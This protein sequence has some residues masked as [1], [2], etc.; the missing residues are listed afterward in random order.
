VVVGAGTVGSRAV[1]LLREVAGVEPAAVVVRDAG[2]ERSFA[3][4]RDLVTADAAAADD[5]DVLVEVAGGTGAAADLALAAL[6]RGAAVVTANKAALAERWDEFAPYLREGLVWCEA[7]V[8]AGAPVVGALTGAL[9][10]CRPVTLHAV[11]NGTCNAI[12]S[13]M[14]AGSSYEAALR[15]AQEAGFAEADPTL[16]VAGIDAA[17]KVALLARLAFDPGL[18]FADV[19]AATRG[20]AGLPR[21][22]VIAHAARGRGVRLVAS[23]FPTEA[24]WRAAVRPVSLPGGH[25]LV[26]SGPAN[27]LVFT[28]R[29]LG[30]VTVRGPGAGGGATATAVVSDVMAALAGGRGHAPVANAADAGA[31]LAVAGP[32]ALPAG[33]EAVAA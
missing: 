18:T 11:L 6:A 4:W 20:V 13:D 2:K 16:D 26:V 1:E 32:S 31:A 10:G 29:P 21:E 14:E 8:M 12:L 22:V 7:A 19:R 5:A 27:A 9:R 30:E 25:P 3:G 17:H 33:A 28:G 15:R 23:V 24:G